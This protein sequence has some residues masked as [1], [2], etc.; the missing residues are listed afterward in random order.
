MNGPY[1]GNPGNQPNFRPQGGGVPGNYGPPGGG[2]G[3]PPNYGYPQQGYPQYFPPPRKSRTPWVV[4]GILSAVV[5]ATGVVAFFLLNRAPAE[6]EEDRIAQLVQ[7]FSVSVDGTDTSEAAAM[8]CD[9]ERE[10]FEER[11]D[12]DLPEPETADET[13]D[14]DVSDVRIEGD[15][16][17]ALIM[18]PP[19]DEAVT[20]YF[21]KESDEWTVC[22]PVEDEL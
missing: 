14:I 7:D 8:L 10:L 21:R 17:S 1:P 20:M 19:D 6:T 16:A 22:A 2:F 11:V 4:G 18:R 13:P 3:P 9:E 15:L 5:V 12:P